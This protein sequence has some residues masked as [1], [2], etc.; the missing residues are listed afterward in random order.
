MK[1]DPQALLHSLAAYPPWLV[2]VC[3]V[4]AGMFTLWLLGKLLKWSLV[5]IVATV[6]ILGGAALVW[7]VLG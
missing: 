3:A 2:V 1:I 6:L 4:V 5:V 7:L